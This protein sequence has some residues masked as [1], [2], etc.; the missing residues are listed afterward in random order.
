MSFNSPSGPVYYADAAYNGRRVYLHT[1]QDHALP[2]FAQ[3]MFVGDSGATWNVLKLDTGHSPFLSEPALLAGIIDENVK[4][5]VA[6][7]NTGGVSVIRGLHDRL[8]YA[9]SAISASGTGLRV[10]AI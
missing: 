7:F 3:D 9:A 8:Q 6:S 4:N 10:S 5:F 1:N 2:P